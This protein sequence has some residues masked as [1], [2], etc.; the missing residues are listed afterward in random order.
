MA[1]FTTVIASLMLISLLKRND[2]SYVIPHIQP[3]VI[4]LTFIF[5]YML[6][7]ENINYKQA[8]GACLIVGGL[9]VINKYKTSGEKI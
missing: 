9:Y 1:A 8:I 3:V 2:A 5:G 7:N 6:F 4:I